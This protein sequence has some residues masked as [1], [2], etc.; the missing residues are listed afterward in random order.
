MPVKVELT[1]IEELTRIT[2]SGR[3]TLPEF[4][5][6]LSA[7]ARNGTTRLEI[8]DVARLDGNRFSSKE[9]DALVDY[10]TSAP[11]RRP[12]GSKTAIV[13]AKT[14]DIGLT[15]MIA[16]LSEGAVPYELEAFRSMEEAMDWLL[17]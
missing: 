5:K 15:R 7:Y 12:T 17:K 13:A 10:L 1:E 16:I 8:Y 2:L 14:V 3:V 11:I 4:L 9:I 6:A